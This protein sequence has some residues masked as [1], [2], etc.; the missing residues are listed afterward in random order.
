MGMCS[1]IT[2]G[3]VVDTKNLTESAAT[4]LKFYRTAH[5][6]IYVMSESHKVVS[7]EELSFPL[8][9][10]SMSFSHQA[11]VGKRR[12]WV[13]GTLYTGCILPGLD[14]R[15]GVKHCQD[16]VF[17][18]QLNGN[19]LSGVFDGH[20]PEGEAV[21]AFCKKFV[22]DFWKRHEVLSAEEPGEYL[23]VMMQEC[24]KKLKSTDSLVDCS[25]SGCTAVLVLFFE[26]SV[27]FASVGDSRAVMG[28]LH[29]PAIETAHQPPRGDDKAILDQIKATRS[30]TSD[31]SL[32]AAQMTLDQKP[33]DPKELERILQCGGVVMRLEDDEGRKVGPYRVWKVE[34]VY[35]GIAMS[36]SLGDSLAHEIGVISTP[37]TSKRRI[38]DSEDFFIVIGSDGIW[39]TMENQ[40]VVDFVEAYRLKCVR[41]MQMPTYQDPVEPLNVTI[42]HLL[43]EEARARW[44]S[45][46]E[47][48]DVLIDDISCVVIELRTSASKKRA[49]A[50]ERAVNLHKDIQDVEGLE[51]GLRRSGTRIRDPKRECVAEKLSEE[52]DTRP[53]G[54]RDQPPVPI[55]DPRRSSVTDIFRGIKL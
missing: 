31:K 22:Y 42:A 24:D 13:S 49:R 30:V 36:R 52:T 16:L 32:L 25:N 41:Q 11:I 23:I 37:L 3:K 12:N 51:K 29:P 26:G 2:A 19:L 55:K 47:A 10:P 17:T 48:E 33:E 15:G 46:V 38:E 1:S 6:H 34:N 54:E 5:I 20:G 28:T 9:E 35:P 18:E 8:T 39:D 40:E 7:D 14:P 50:P 53:E 4:P 43:C 21:V 27:Y 45:I 44:L